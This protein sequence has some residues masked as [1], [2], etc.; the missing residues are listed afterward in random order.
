MKMWQGRFQKEEDESVNDF[1]SSISFD[2]RMYREDITGSIAHAR[3]L[4]KCGIIE[5]SESEKIIEGLKGILSDLESGALE[6][7]MKAEDI[8]MFVEEVLT[9]RIGDAGKRLHTSRSR[10]DQVALDVRM[11]LMREMDEVMAHAVTNLDYRMRKM[12][13]GDFTLNHNDI[14]NAPT[15]LNEGNEFNIVDDAGYIALKIGSDGVEAAK[16]SAS[17]GFFQTSDE[18]LKEF[19]GDINVNFEKLKSIPKVYYTW[20]DDVMGSQ[21]IG[22]SAQKVQEVY[23]EIVTTNTNTGKLAVDYAKLSVIA[24]K[25]VDVLYEENAAL[26]SELNDMKNELKLIKEKLGL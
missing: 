22:T 9:K 18:T 26:R 7:D 19:H 8:H 5:M 15:T 17:A 10:N 24:L 1:N 20:K 11:Y 21:Q 3:M 14:E 4:G 25:A 16:V 13:S 2:S 12:E 6:F 23:P